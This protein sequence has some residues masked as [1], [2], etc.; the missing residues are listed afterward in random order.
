MKL[1][2][3]VFGGAWAACALMVMFVLVM[4]ATGAPFIGDVTIVGIF[5]ALWITASFLIYHE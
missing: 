1:G 4:I 2:F 3:A 5:L